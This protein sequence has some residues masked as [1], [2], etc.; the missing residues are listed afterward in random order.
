MIIADHETYEA[1]GLFGLLGE[2]GLAA[3]PDD[4]SAYGFPEKVAL[5]KREAPAAA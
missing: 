4:V 3:L 5:S 2:A 1:C